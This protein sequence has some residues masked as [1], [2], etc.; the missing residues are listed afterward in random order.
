MSF[1]FK[2]ENI[3]F[4]DKVDQKFADYVLDPIDKNQILKFLKHRPNTVI[5]LI[6]NTNVD[7]C[8]QYPKLAFEANVKVVEN[9][10]DAYREFPFHLIHISTDQIYDSKGPN[11]ES[12][13]NPINV[14]A[15]TKYCS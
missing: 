1:F 12:K 5:N 14:Y 6:A 13:I 2:K 8:E 9:I 3:K 4:C 10:V 11:I 7:E 15:I